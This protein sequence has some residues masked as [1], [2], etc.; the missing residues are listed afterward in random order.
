MLQRKGIIGPPP[1][2]GVVLVFTRRFVYNQSGKKGIISHLTGE[3][4]TINVSL[5]A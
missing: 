3:W 2:Y 1:N 4:R 5:G